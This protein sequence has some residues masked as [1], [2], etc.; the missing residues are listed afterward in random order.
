MVQILEFAVLVI[1]I[2]ASG[3]MAPGPLFAASVS[4]GL[5]EVTRAGFKMAIGHTIVELPLVI[6]LGIGAFS[7]ESFPGFRT[8]ISIFGAITLFVFAT[9]QIKTTLGGK[10]LVLSNP[11]HGPLIAGIVLS[12]LNPFFIIWWLAIG[13]KLISDA[14]LMWSFVGILIVFG[15]HIWMDFA[16]LGTVSFLASKSSKILSNKNYKVVM[17]GLSLMLIYFGIMFLVDILP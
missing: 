3:V 6:L 16:W 9:I 17:I 12:A 8:I 7:L 11:K 13:F 2:S 10:E 15:L 4:Y 14:M 5:R 1:V